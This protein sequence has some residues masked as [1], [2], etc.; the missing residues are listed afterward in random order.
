[1]R[2][3]TAKPSK[4]KAPPVD[5]DSLLDDKPTEPKV[6]IGVYKGVQRRG[7]IVYKRDDHY[8][9]TVMLSENGGQRVLHKWGADTFK[10]NMRP[11]PTPV[12]YKGKGYPLERALAVYLK[13]DA[14]YEEAAY[15]VLVKLSKGQDPDEEDTLDDL[16]DTTPSPHR[17]RGLRGP[18]GMRT[19]QQKAER[20]RKR[21]EKFANMTPAALKQFREARNARRRMR[22]ANAKKA[23]TK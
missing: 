1:M 23:R 22:R 11:A 9:W 21:Q 19:Q 17:A 16:L 3:A 14:V 6:F 7:C 10:A 2:K 4:N 8:V 5:L 13:P 15:R 20:R 12:G 18:R